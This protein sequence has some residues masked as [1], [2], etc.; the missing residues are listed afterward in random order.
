MR[1]IRFVSLAARIAVATFAL[2]ACSKGAVTPFVPSDANSVQSSSRL[3]TAPPSATL[4]NG[5]SSSAASD[6]LPLIQETDV[7]K[8]FCGDSVS[9]SSSTSLAHPC[10]HVQYKRR[11]SVVSRHGTSL[12]VNAPYSSGTVDT[13]PA[14][15][16][17]CVIQGTTGGIGT[18]YPTIPQGSATWFATGLPSGASYTWKP[19]TSSPPTVVSFESVITDSS[20]KIGSYLESVG[21]T[22]VGT[23]DANGNPVGCGTAVWRFYVLCSLALKTC[24]QAAI[25]DQRQYSSGVPKEVDGTPPPLQQVAMARRW[26]LRRSGKPV[27]VAEFIHST[28]RIPQH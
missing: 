19:A 15:A 24:P 1:R 25:I 8:D 2:A 11:F 6:T 12:A 28:H 18:S 23:K 9:R 14:D 26:T 17:F 16:V 22:C 4:L 5:P 7:A 3:Q 13:C 21:A 20:A 10:S 27:L